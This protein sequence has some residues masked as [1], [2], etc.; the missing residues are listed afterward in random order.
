MITLAVEPSAD[1]D[2]RHRRHAAR[3]G[4]HEDVGHAFEA[5]GEDVHARAVEPAL[6]FG[7]RLELAQ[8]NRP[9]PGL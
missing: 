7:Q 6:D 1:V 3:P 2:A 8:G 9:L 5:R 4:L